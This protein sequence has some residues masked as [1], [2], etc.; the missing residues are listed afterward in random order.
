[1]V[2]AL[3]F[4]PWG[5]TLL[6]I[7]IAIYSIVKTDAKDDR[8]ETKENAIDA[9]TVIVKLENIQNSVNKMSD[10]MASMQT[11]M[12]SLDHRLVVV[13]TKLALGVVD[14]ANLEV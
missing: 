13:E 3:N 7:L 6:S 14:A 2:D 1:M 12:E 10:S 5:F 8:K 11:K 4:I 9:T